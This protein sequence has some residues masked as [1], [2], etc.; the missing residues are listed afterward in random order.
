MLYTILTQIKAVLNSKTLTR[1]SYDPNDVQF[2]TPGHFLIG[3]R[4]TAYRERNIISV[5]NRLLIYQHISQIQQ[6][7]WQRWSV[8]Y[9]NQLLSWP[10]WYKTSKNLEINSLVLLIM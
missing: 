6:L 5:N 1:I 9:L 10:K 3:T 8:D 4:I 7:F 2:L